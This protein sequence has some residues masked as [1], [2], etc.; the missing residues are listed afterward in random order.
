MLCGEALADP[1][2]LVVNCAESRLQ[3]VIGGEAG[4]AWSELFKSPGGSMPLLAPSIKRGLAFCGIRPQG[5]QGI[6]YVRGPGSFT[7]LR[8][9]LAHVLGLAQATALPVAGLDY[10]ELLARAPSSMLDFP[11][12]CITHSRKKQVYARKFFCPQGEPAQDPRVFSVSEMRG[13]LFKSGR[14][15]VLGSGVLRN[16]EVLPEGGMVRVLPDFF[17]H[18]GP[19]VLLKAAFV[20]DF[21]HEFTPPLYL[22]A[23]DAEQNLKAIAARRGLDMDRAGRELGRDLPQTTR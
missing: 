17:N 9:S 6:A 16:P 13:E 15:F 22:R 23:S 8:V 18:P 11:L 5:L 4:V 7:G 3:L 1:L 2:Y 19:D 14:C 10:L 12:W 20:A 21:S